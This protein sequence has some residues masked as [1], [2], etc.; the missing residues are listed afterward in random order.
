[1]S[2]LQHIQLWM[3]S[4]LY[5]HKLLLTLVGAL[6]AIAFDLDIYFQGYLAVT[7]PILWIIFICGTNTTHEEIMSIGQKSRSHRSFESLPSGMG[8]LSKS[9]I[10]N[11][12]FVLSIIKNMYGSM[13]KFH[14]VYQTLNTKLKI[15][16]PVPCKYSG[17]H[18]IWIHI[19]F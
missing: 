6:H 10:Y 16:S 19:R 13:L 18:E 1:M 8:Y 3:N 5:W 14:C 7:L 11:F 2:T 12:Y 9:P 17:V 4:C 15:L